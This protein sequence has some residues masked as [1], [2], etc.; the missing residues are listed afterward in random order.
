VPFE[1]AKARIRPET[2]ESRIWHNGGGQSMT[3]V[4]ITENGML[5][6]QNKIVLF[7]KMFIYAGQRF[8]FQ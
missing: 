3:N 5:A 7:N 2:S 4:S 6:K 8:I 1:A